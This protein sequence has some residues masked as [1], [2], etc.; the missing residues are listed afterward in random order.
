VHGLQIAAR[1]RQIETIQE[2][3]IL[4]GARLLGI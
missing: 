1:S 2:Q 4:N 3:G